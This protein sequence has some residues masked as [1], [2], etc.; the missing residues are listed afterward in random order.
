MSVL[1]SI[2][3]VNRRRHYA[4]APTL[5]DAWKPG[6]ATSAA[7]SS[8]SSNGG[9]AVLRRES[10]PVVHAPW[11]SGADGADRASNHDHYLRHGAVDIDRA[12]R[13]G[14]SPDAMARSQSYDDLPQPAQPLPAQLPLRPALVDLL[15]PVPG[16]SAADALKAFSWRQSTTRPRMSMHDIRDMLARASFVE[17]SASGTASRRTSDGSGGFDI[18]LGARRGSTSTESSTCTTE[19][20]TDAAERQQE[21]PRQVPA[22]E[23]VIEKLRE[24]LSAKVPSAN[25]SLKSAATSAGATATSSRAS[26]ELA[27]G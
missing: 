21:E 18:C 15:S 22:P 6:V 14:R 4:A 8:S 10:S 25:G 17:S 23:E 24:T 3:N 7:Q 16:L 27:G 5:E 12:K 13:K 20:S 11:A 9:R 26:F 1:A 19:S 2:E